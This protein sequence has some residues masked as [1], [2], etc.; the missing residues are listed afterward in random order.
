MRDNR[1]EECFMTLLKKKIEESSKEGIRDK[2]TEVPREISVKT[3]KIAVKRINPPLF[4]QLW[5]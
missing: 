4:W 2:R 3:S 1:F 5:Q